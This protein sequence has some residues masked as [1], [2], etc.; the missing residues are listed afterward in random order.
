MHGKGILV[1]PL[2][3]VSQMLLP[4]IG[5][6]V[7]FAEWVQL[8]TIWIVIQ[9]IGIAIITIGVFTLSYFNEQKRKLTK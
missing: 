6:I 3:A 1:A 9:S 4:I 5:G 8:A 2:Y 7:V